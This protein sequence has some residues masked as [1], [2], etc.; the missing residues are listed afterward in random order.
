MC[1]QSVSGSSLLSS[2]N[3]DDARETS[4]RSRREFEQIDA[5][6][7]DEEKT[8]HSTIKQICEE[9]SNKPHFRVRG[10][11]YRIESNETIKSPRLNDTHVDDATSDR[12][13]IDSIEGSDLENNLEFDDESNTIRSEQSSRTAIDSFDT[14]DDDDDNNEQSKHPQY[15][16]KCLKDSIVNSL[17]SDL[18]QN[19]LSQQQLI[20]QK[21]FELLCTKNSIE[22]H[23]K[24]RPFS[25]PPRS[26]S[27]NRYSLPSTSAFL[28]STSLPARSTPEPGLKLNDLLHVKRLRVS[29]T[30]TNSMPMNSPRKSQTQTL[31]APPPTERT[32]TS[33][34]LRQQQQISLVGTAVANPPSTQNSLRRIPSA[35]RYRSAT[36][37]STNMQSIEPNTRLPPITIERLTSTDQ[38]ILNRSNQTT[39]ETI[40]RA[41]SG[42]SIGS[43]L[44]S[45]TKLR[46][47]NQL[48]K[49]QRIHRPTT[50]N[51]S[52]ISTT[53]STT[54]ISSAFRPTQQKRRLVTTKPPPTGIIK[55]SA[56]HIW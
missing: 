40:P 51:S 45:T 23:S 20:L 37:I 47:L 8:K 1:S 2:Y 36:T 13:S 44:S 26:L 14:D 12:L 19:F 16:I 48:T 4:G 25:L 11:F 18:I 6:L 10:R 38:F 49:A 28:Q 55:I 33:L 31:L 54:T 39:I 24:S 52:T 56:P 3:E 50:M 15:L 35:H 41:V 42:T 46:T 9:W 29:T 30:G 21:Y 34:K 7:Y 27:Q 32:S 5:V 43:N 17:A 53:R 22:I